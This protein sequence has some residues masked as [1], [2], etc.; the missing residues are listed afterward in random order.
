MTSMPAM[1]FG[2]DDRG[3]VQVGKF[4]DITVF[5]ADTVQDRAT[6]TD[7]HHYSVGIVHRVGERHSRH[8]GRLPDRREA[9]DRLAG[10]GAALASPWTK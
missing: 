7:P 6:Y 10:T 9:R 3:L 4:A 2:Q 8:Q 5:D 1:Q